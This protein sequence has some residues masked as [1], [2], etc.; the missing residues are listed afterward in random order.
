[1]IV[2]VTDPISNTMVT[3]PQDHPYIIQGEG[4][5]STKIYFENQENKERYLK[6]YNFK[7]VTTDLS[8]QFR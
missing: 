1:M 4:R 3:K 7:S 6:L 2:M 8:P 5:N